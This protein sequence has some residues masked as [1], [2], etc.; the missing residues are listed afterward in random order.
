[1]AVT[2]RVGVIRQV[3]N[4]LRKT[5][6]SDYPDPMFRDVYVGPNFQLAREKYPAIYVAYQESNIRQAG[7]GHKLNI[8]D[9]EGLDR[10]VQQAI[11]EGAIQFTVMA[12]TPYERDVLLDYVSDILLFSRR[13]GSVNKSVFWQQIHTADYLWL[14]LNSENVR[15]GGVS[16]LPAPWQAEND[17]LFTGSYSISSEAEFFS[18]VNTSNLVPINKIKVYPYRSD[19]PIPQGVSDPAEWN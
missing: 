6:D 9:D 18:D 10:V 3:T 13:D 1:M 5:F 7:L 16:S 4:A 8:I 14:T 19:Q 11:A 12:L 15:P 2:H 17:L